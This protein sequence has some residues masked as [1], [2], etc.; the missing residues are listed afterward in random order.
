M[1]ACPS[2]TRSPSEEMHIYVEVRNLEIEMLS[3]KLPDWL[4]LLSGGE[5]M[6]KE[7]FLRGNRTEVL[8]I[9]LRVI[10]AET[11]HVGSLKAHGIT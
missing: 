9:H 7:E 8:R 11:K 6:R 10:V 1:S 5:R 3:I 2:V 4:H